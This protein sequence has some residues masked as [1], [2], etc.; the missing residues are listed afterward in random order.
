MNN[1]EKIKNMSTDEM[2]EFIDSFIPNCI[3]F[4]CPVWD[5]CEEINSANCK[6]TLKQW[7]ESEV[8][9]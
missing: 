9:K 7:L 8:L 4:I 1:Y 6:N 2:V 3:D 5:Y